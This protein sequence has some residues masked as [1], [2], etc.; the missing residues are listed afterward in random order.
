MEPNLM[1][2]VGGWRFPEDFQ[3]V[4]RPWG[5][6]PRYGTAGALLMGDAAHPVS[7]AGGQG[8]NMSIADG[9][10]IAEL[11]LAGERDLVTIYE[12]RRR[13]ANRRSLRF[14]RAAAFAFGLPEW[15]FF[16]RLSLW[17]V[18]QMGRRPE[19]IARLV[20]MASRAFLEG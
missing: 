17:L 15:L 8:A 13:P 9:R 6:A 3:R 14:T 12:R 20:R 1:A 7:P 16:S 10:V 5:H 18:R 4:R 2:L 11:A 19:L